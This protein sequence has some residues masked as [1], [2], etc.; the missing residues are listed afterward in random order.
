MSVSRPNIINLPESFPIRKAQDF[1]KWIDLLLKLDLGKEEVSKE[2][3][4]P[5]NSSRN[6][7]IEALSKAAPV[8]SGQLQQ[9][10][11]SLQG[12][13]IGRKVSRLGENNFSLNIVSN[14]EIQM[15]QF[16]PDIEK[17]TLGI[18]DG[19]L[20]SVKVS[21]EAITSYRYN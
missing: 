10:V 11:D 19:K 7:S 18:H 3:S 12:I 21:R 13:G 1:T 14:S 2:S 5:R 6:I 20:T 17:L 9:A 8:L 15:Q 16:S 4:N